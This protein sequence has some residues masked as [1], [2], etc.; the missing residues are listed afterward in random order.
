MFNALKVSWALFLGLSLI[1]VGNG[2]GG[3]LVGVRTQVEDFGNTLTGFV[4]AGYF[5]GFFVGSAVVPRMMAAVGHVRVFGAL[6]ALA[7]LSILIYPLFI[8]PWV[9]TLMRIMTGIAY[10][11]LYIVVESW[12]NEKATNETRGQI[13]GIYLV[14]SFT[15][16]AGGQLLLNL[17][18]PA[19]FELFT[20][21]SVLIS[22]AAVPVLISAARAP[23]FEAPES[24]GPIRL[25]R[26]SPLG[27][28]GMVLVGA[29]A[30][31]L[32][33]MGP[34]YGFKM[35]G[36]EF[37]SL[38]MTAV[39]IGG[40][41]FTWPIGKMSDLFD[42]RT[43]IVATAIACAG[44]GI[45]GIFFEPPGPAF[46]YEPHHPINAIEAGNT[47]SQSNLLLLVGLLFG[48]LA[49]PL[50]S[51]CIAHTNDHLTTKQMVAAS[52][53]LIM[54]NGMGAVIG[55]NIGGLAMDLM[56]M[57]GF[58]WSLIA[59]NVLFGVFG[60]YRMTVRPALAAED[61]GS[62]VAVDSRMTAVA[63]TAF[64]PEV[65]WPETEQDADLF[66]DG[67]DEIDVATEPDGTW[68]DLPEATQDSAEGSDGDEDDLSRA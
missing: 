10:A 16:V 54:A 38:F 52:S 31:I 15:G 58:F 57:P 22:L 66:E 46:N 19:N 1:M 67:A 4:M 24:M 34:A 53:T 32:I 12:L 49:L 6:T 7:S 61:Q 28:F 13:L 14:V 30:G 55:P 9:W 60:L 43:V 42:R 35:Y 51:L 26:I 68:D 17:Y 23:E 18:D 29:T 25:Y 41:L 59:I 40:F 45:F 50:Y 3:T 62:F 47:F 2:L 21:V 11:G 48:G 44:V 65:E 56:G 37:A 36:T 64:H 20:V 63:T 8:D 27:T 5:L 33:G 39:F